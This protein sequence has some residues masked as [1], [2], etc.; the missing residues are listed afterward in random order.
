MAVHIESEGRARLLSSAT[1]IPTTAHLDV[2]WAMG[3][4]LDPLR[5]IEERKRF[6]ASADFAG[7]VA[8][9]VPARP[10]RA[11]RDAA[12]WTTAGGFFWQSDITEIEPERASRMRMLY[13]LIGVSPM[14]LTA[15]HHDRFAM[16]RD[17]RGEMLRRP[18]L[19]EP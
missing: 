5:T 16:L 8:D 9:T 4:D 12:A 13:C 17:R 6:Y 1:S 7:K 15:G 2:G 18:R 14:V 19:D 3:F 11:A 10:P